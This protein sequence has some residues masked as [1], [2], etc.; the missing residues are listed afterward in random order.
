MP[1]A[2]VRPDQEEEVGEA[3]DRCAEVRARAALPRVGDAA[4]V[5]AADALGDGRVG[6]VEA[7]AEDDRVDFALYPVG[8]H[9]A[10]GA[11]LRH[12]V[13]HERRVR[14]GE[15]RV[16]G[17]REQHALAAEREVRRERGAQLWVVHLLVHVANHELADP[18]HHRRAALGQLHELERVVEGAAE[19]SL[20]DRGLAVERLLDR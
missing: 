13:R 5:R 14:L 4:P 7:R 1:V 8:A 17:V 18:V 6:H 3:G 9:D 11:N 16:V 2:E 12:R 20:G 19:R 15:R 10:L